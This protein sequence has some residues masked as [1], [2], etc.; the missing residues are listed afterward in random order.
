MS[1]GHP[2]IV[3]FRQYLW[4]MQTKDIIR[5]Y[6]EGLQQKQGWEALIADDMDFKGPK[7]RTTDKD[8]YIQA[9][10][11]FLRMVRSVELRSII[12]EDEDAAAIADYQ[13]VSPSGK[14]GLITLAEIFMIKEEKIASS[15]IYFDTAAFRDFMAG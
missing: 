5:R 10:I 15:V 8:G 12:A 3:P 14:T 11:S 4:P 7:T 13:L 2:L 1:V 9:T 6:Y